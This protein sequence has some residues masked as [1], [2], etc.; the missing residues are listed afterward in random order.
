MIV[1]GNVSHDEALTQSIGGS[2]STVGRTQ[3]GEDVFNVGSDRSITYDE[4][5]ADLLIRQPLGG[6]GENLEFTPTQWPDIDRVHAHHGH[7]RL[8]PTARNN[9]NTKPLIAIGP[10]E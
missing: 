6:E 9:P 2:G 10:D 3:L 7:D 5:V 4:G 1:T 8:L